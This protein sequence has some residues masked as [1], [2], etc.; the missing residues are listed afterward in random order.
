MRTKKAA[1]NKLTVPANYVKL[2]EGEE[3]PTSAAAAV[4]EPPP[5]PAAALAPAASKG[6]TATS[7]YDYEAAEDNELSFPEGATILN[8]VSLS[9]KICRYCP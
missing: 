4:A 2:E 3:E 8:L 9:L 5:A 1:A 7:E 6:P